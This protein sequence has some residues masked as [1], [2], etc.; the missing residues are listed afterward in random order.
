MRDTRGINRPGF[1]QFN[2]FHIDMVEQPDSAT[3]QDWRQ[4]NLYFVKQSS[5]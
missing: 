3:E 1:F 5:V 2:L 4:V